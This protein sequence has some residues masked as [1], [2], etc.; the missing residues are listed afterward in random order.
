MPWHGPVVAKVL[1]LP[2][3]DG[4]GI[5]EEEVTAPRGPGSCQARLK[6]AVGRQDARS[7]A[8]SPANGELVAEGHLELQ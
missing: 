2:G 3:S 5:N 1:A 8:D 4:V 6:N 7:A